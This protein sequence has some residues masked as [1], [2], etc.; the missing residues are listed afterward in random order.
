MA[1]KREREIKK[2]IKEVQQ[3]L[4]YL[5]EKEKCCSLDKFEEYEIY[6]LQ[7]ELD[8]LETELEELE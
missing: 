2:R 5:E 1:T 3:E 7:V 4:E 6:D 8:N